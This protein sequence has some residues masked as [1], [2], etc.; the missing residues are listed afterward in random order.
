M[1]SNNVTLSVESRIGLESKSELD[2]ILREGA[3][4]LLQQAI[5]LEVADYIETHKSLLDE[6]NHR[7]VVRN[8]HMP[9]RHL[10]TGVG[11]VEIKRPRVNDRRDGHRFSSNII[12]RFMR[13]SPSLS[14][15]LPILYLKGISSGDFS[16]ALESIVGKDAGNLSASTIVRLKQEWESEYKIWTKRDLSHKRYVYWW[17]DGIH[18]NVRLEDERTCMLVIMGTREDGHKELIGIVDG[19]R[20]SKISW[21][22]LLRDLKKQGLTDAPRLAVADGALGFWAALSEEFPEVKE[23]RCWV[24]KTANILD[25]MPKNIQPRAKEKIHEMYLSA[26]RREA[27]D[28]YN[29]FLKLYAKK[30][31]GACE[32]LKKDKD[33]LFT[34][35]DFPAEHWKHIRT[36]NPI[37]ST[38]ATVRHRTKRTKGCGSR[39]ATLTM[40]YKLSREAEKKW[41][42]INGQKMISKI[43]QGIKFVDGEIEIA[44]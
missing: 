44:A 27:L 40:V 1:G 29:Q 20:E 30:Y 17:A 36:T 11:P 35:Y 5:E 25:K 33:V 26:T 16:D 19:Y 34:F 21:L 10:V 38:F 15:L 6:N 28:A 3:R 23:Q 42:R 39:M 22:D 12:P 43:F 37:E 41:R 8:G 32:C 18:F 4:R 31:P 9:A 14:T 24:H 2:Q 7:L 13:R